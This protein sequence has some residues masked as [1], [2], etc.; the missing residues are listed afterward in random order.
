MQTLLVE[1]GTEEI[2]AGYIEP[3]LNALS[4]ALQ[5]KL[6]DARI[7]HGPA[8]VYGTPRRLTVRIEQVAAKQKSLSMEVLGPP[9]KVGLDAKGK[10][11]VAA[12]KFAEKV[13]VSVASLKV[14]ETAKGDYLFAK[15]TER[16]LQAK[17]ILKDIL[18]RV[19]LS[20]PFPKTMR[21]ARLDIAFAR[22]IHWVLALLGKQTIPFE[23]GDLKS[24][25]YTTGHYFMHRGRIKIAD[26]A[27]YVE[28]LRAADV[29]V[30]L[31]E[32][33]KEVLKE[34]TRAAK[35]AGGRILEDAELL[36]TVTNLVEYPV[37]TTGK[38]EDE[39][40][41]LPSEILIT[42]MREH[43]KYFAVVNE[44][45]KL[46]PCFIAVNNTR[47]R[48]TGL[49]AKGH[50]RVL[51]ARLKDAQF[52]YRSDLEISS[53]ERVEK[54]KGVLFQAELGTVHEKILRVQKLASHLSA[55][56]KWK[57]AAADQV[58][59]AAYLCKADL[60][61]HVV[62]E[63]PK[64]QGVMG[65]VYA[66]VSGEKGDVPAAV[67]EH[68]RP[69][70]SGG[71]LPETVTG[72]VLS[73]ADK[74]DSI[75]G[76]F[77]VGLLPTGASDPYAL[78]RQA[79]GVIQILLDQKFT[80]SLRETIEQSVELFGGKKGSRQV[81]EAADKVYTFF[82]N[83]I[84]HLLAEEGFSKDVIAAVTSVSVDLPPD[85]WERVRA[86]EKLKADPD[87]EPLATAFKRVVNIIRKAKKSE[88]VALDPKL[89]QDP[90]EKALHQSCTAVEKKV[91]RNLKSGR[92]TEAL[93]DIAT[94]RDS[95][96]RFF[97][98]VL[99]MT[100]DMTTRHNRLALLR[101]I[102]DLFAGFADFSKLST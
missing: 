51:R 33:K 89:F 34:I 75:C 40:L 97:E 81:R 52:F 31:R 41:Q 6:D 71:A 93:L 65:R 69:T 74:M 21:W 13:G 12:V 7:D 28:A 42:A 72:A 100:D 79:I 85:V 88:F 70:Y 22:P 45:G 66:A 32:R 29:L 49:V 77:S 90:S 8:R 56:A 83:R 55:A 43:Q 87:F 9:A 39:F 2:P 10:P 48:D 62:G 78:R 26:P 44:K 91:A 68:Y 17:T 59:R 46:L 76:C 92:F 84:A 14:K 73:I 25:R 30:D 16:G 3:A 57:K 19:I 23:I 102:A 15:K 1:I 58:S 27:A 36:D 86:L 82:E 47:T 5:R 54:L 4:S 50:E 38:F 94:L 61:S 24:G 99:V 80:F 96:D 20:T 35:T 98:D 101:K 53:E 60:V 67:E 11:T 18:P 95:V 64:L 37:A 63:F